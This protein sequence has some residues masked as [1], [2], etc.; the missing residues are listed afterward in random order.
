L[1]SFIDPSQRFPSYPRALHF[2]DKCHPFID[3]KERHNL[4]LLCL[5]RSFRRHEWLFFVLY[6]GCANTFVSH[7]CLS[8][9]LHRATEMSYTGKMEEEGTL[10]KRAKFLG[11][12]KSRGNGLHRS[13]RTVLHLTRFHGQ[14]TA[15]LERYTDE[16]GRLAEGLQ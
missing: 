12:N 8:V 10:V 9:C 15:D 3:I 13:C 16:S 6:C 11:G 5:N 7:I 1:P 2:S 14:L 4:L